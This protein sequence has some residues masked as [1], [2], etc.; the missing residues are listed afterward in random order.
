MC[1]AGSEYEMSGGGV[2][3]PR[4]TQND[5]DFCLIL[6]LDRAGFFYLRLFSA[7]S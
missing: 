2:V 7:I 6:T 4:A 1:G 3:A 5:A